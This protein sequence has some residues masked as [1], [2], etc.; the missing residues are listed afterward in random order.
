MLDPVEARLGALIDSLS[1]A[2]RAGLA[3]TIATQVQM[4]NEGFK[5]YDVNPNAA[6]QAVLVTFQK[7]LDPTSVVRESEY[8]RTFDG[9]A[10]LDRMQRIR[11]PAEI[12]ADTGTEAPQDQAAQAAVSAAGE[13]V[14]GTGEGAADEPGAFPAPAPDD[15]RRP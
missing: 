9:Q 15:G 14:P 1:P 7:I 8:A 11:T 2:S 10:I 5:N 13:S 4:M 6:S 12:A 3:R